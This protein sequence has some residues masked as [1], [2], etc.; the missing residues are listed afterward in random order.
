MSE[1]LMFGDL[2]IKNLLTSSNFCLVNGFFELLPDIFYE[3]YTIQV[4]LLGFAPPCV[5]VL[6]P[7]KMEKNL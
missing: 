4:E 5:Y 6:L 2:A 3:L 1:F 7:N